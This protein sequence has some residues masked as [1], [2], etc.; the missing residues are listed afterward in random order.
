MISKETKKKIKEIRELQFNNHMNSYFKYTTN[1]KFHKQNRPLSTDFNMMKTKINDNIFYS[2]LRNKN[3]Q[4]YKNNSKI[5]SLFS[6]YKSFNPYVTMMMTKGA[7]KTEYN[8]TKYV[9]YDPAQ[10]T[11]EFSRNELAKIQNKKP[12]TCKNKNR[13]FFG[14]D[15][16]TKL[17]KNLYSNSMKSLYMQSFSGTGTVYSAS[18]P[19]L[20]TAK[21]DKSSFFMPTV[22]NF[23]TEDQKYAE[24]IFLDEN[25]SK[26]NKLIDKEDKKDFYGNYNISKKLTYEE[27]TNIEKCF[28]ENQKVNNNLIFNPI[29]RGIN[30]E[31]N[32]IVSTKIL[33]KDYKDPFKSLKKLKLNSQMCNLIQQMRI[34]IQCQKYQNKYDDICELNIE[35]NRMPN[36]KILE[37]NKKSNLEKLNDDDILKIFNAEPKKR[38]N[39]SRKTTK[40]STI[41]NK[42]PENNNIFLVNEVTRSDKLHELKLEIFIGCFGHHPELRTMNGLTYNKENGALYIHGGIGGKKYGDIWDFIFTSEKVGWRKIYEPKDKDFEN[43]PLPRYGHTIHYYKEK[44]YLI[45]GQFDNWNSNYNKEGIMCIFDLNKGYWNMLKDDYDIDAIKKKI[46]EDLKNKMKKEESLNLL[47]LN[48][49]N[50][51]PVANNLYSRNININGIN[52]YSTNIQKY[53]LLNKNKENNNKKEYSCSKLSE[54][55]KNGNKIKI[56]TNHNIFNKKT[57]LTTNKNLINERNI[58]KI[59]NNSALTIQTKLNNQNDIIEPEFEI[60]DEDIQH[61][62]PQFP[63]LRRNHISLLIGYNIFIY[64]G[65]NQNK[66][67]LNDC[68]VYDLNTKKWSILEFTGRYPPPLGHHCACLALENNQNDIDQLNVYHKPANERKTKPILKTEGIF[69]FGGTNDNYT[70]TNLFFQMSIGIKPAIFEIPKTNGKPPSPRTDSSMNFASSISMIIIHG[71]KNEMKSEFYNDIFML[72]LKNMDWVHPLFQDEIPL[73]RAEHKSIVISDC[74]FILGGTSSDHLLNFDFMIV[75]LNFFEN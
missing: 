60:K 73:E 36:I 14:I 7:N 42:Q 26:N 35:K 5:A 69:F 13:T 63:T 10:Q 56:K 3:C 21:N 48:N 19:R 61:L 44:I 34:N 1:I 53:N 8:H 9:E 55:S 51:V 27:E 39:K 22:V 17:E 50:N 4:I 30:T 66:V 20:N 18:S 38:K 28:I 40:Q 6:D 11:H 52:T 29:F 74:L 70:P 71:G 64:G 43:E 57:K 32:N 33:K 67:Y 23:T 65:I 47:Y 12:Q 62:L 72:D 24:D 41:N 49:I 46:K 59:R 58:H 16:K 15:G 37:K 54:I 31:Y 45:G 2:R 68:W 25:R 75:N